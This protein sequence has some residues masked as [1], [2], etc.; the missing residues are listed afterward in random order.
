MPT[1]AAVRNGQALAALPMYDWPEVRAATD[2]IWAG[3][4]AELRKRRFNA[5]ASLAREMPDDVIWR[6]PQLLIAQTCGYP[7]V[8][9]LQ[10][11]VRIVATP[12]YNA[13]GCMGSHYCSHIVVRD[14]EQAQTLHEMAGRT[15]AIN[16]MCSQSGFAALHKAVSEL[17]GPAPFFA[18]ATFTG[19]HRRSLQAVADGAADIAAVDAVCWAMARRYLP[20]LTA[21]LKSIATTAR[22]PGLPLVTARSRS[23]RDVDLIVEALE[24]CLADPGMAEARQLLFLQAVERIPEADYRAAYKALDEND[25]ALLIPRVRANGHPADKPTIAQNRSR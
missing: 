16:A 11:R 25:A 17:Q 18:A 12:A 24:D 15:V 1:I 13:D 3:L 19:G 5:P 20:D 22:T 21:R 2:T 4:A 7:F 10:D 8:T 23:D 9:E 14:D 6:D